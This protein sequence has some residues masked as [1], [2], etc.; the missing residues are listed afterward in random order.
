MPLIMAEIGVIQFI[1]KINGKGDTKQFLKNLG[2]QEGNEIIII[3]RIHDNI[4][5]KIKETRVAIDKSIA[6]KI[7]V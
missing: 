1:K 6:N 4:I 3:S 5:V 7:I 2:F